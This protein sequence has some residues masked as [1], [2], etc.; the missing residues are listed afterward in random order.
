MKILGY[1]APLPPAPPA[2]FSPAERKRLDVITDIPVSKLSKAD[3]K[4]LD[5]YEG[6]SGGLTGRG[7]TGHRKSS[8]SW[9]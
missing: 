7:L 5:R 8:R 1:V 3:R 4:L 9:R 6:A 2:K